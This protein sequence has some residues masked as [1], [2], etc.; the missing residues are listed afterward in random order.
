M[1]FHK[2]DKAKDKDF[3]SVR[4]SRDVRLI[5]PP[6]RGEPLALLRRPPRQGYRSIGRMSGLPMRV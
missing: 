1:S 3:W 4:V 6:D 2:L 5:V